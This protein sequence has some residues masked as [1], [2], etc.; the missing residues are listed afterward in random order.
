MQQTR[1]SLEVY[2]EYD[3]D[4]QRLIGIWV[5]FPSHRR[6][7]SLWRDIKALVQLLEDHGMS[8]PEL[9]R[10]QLH[11]LQPGQHLVYKEA[12][13]YGALNTIGNPLEWEL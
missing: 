12:V 11:L 5:S 4:S 6:T 1:V 3:Q 2:G 13:E 8:D 9:T 7:P 10:A